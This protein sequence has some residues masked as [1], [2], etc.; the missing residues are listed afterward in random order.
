MNADVCKLDGCEKIARGRGLCAAH[1]SKLLKYGDPLAGR[2]NDGGTCKVDDCSAAL[3]GLGMC[4]LHYERFKKHGDPLVARAVRRCK[5]DGCKE[6][7]K[8]NGYCEFHN[9]RAQRYDGN[10]LGGGPRHNPS[11]SQG[12]KCKADG[13]DGVAKHL[14]YCQK[15]YSK[16]KKY[17]DPLLG[18]IL[19]GRSKIWHTRKGGYIIKFERENQYAN[20][21][22]GIVFQHAEVMGKAIGRR[23]LP[24][25]SVHHKNGDRADNRIE[26]LELWSKAQPAGQRVQD[27]VAWAKE[28]LQLYGDVVDK[29]L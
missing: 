5:V 21:I 2:S 23:L 4:R 11:G 17:G 22:S 10:P 3:H 15:H 18:G 19:D 28:I 29:L 8:A 14:F 12:G 24:N 27:K 25:E 16:F 1:Y 13:C 20:K 26:N 7:Y 9:G 6:K